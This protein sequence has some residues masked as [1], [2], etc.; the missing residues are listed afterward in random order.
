MLELLIAASFGGFD[1]QECRVAF[2]RREEVRLVLILRPE[3]PLGRASTTQ[4]VN[5]LLLQSDANEFSLAM[6]RLE[7]YPWLSN[8]LSRQ[9]SS[10]R[11]WN[12]AA[13]KPQSGSDN[14]YVSNA[15]AGMPEFTALFDRWRVAGVSVEKVL[16]RPAREI[17]LAAGAPVPPDARLPWDAIVWVYLKAP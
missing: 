2:E 11:R 13:G 14:A 12:L 15:L 5:R 1:A 6:G 10:S 17:Q 9:A 3:C 7:R 4:A 8:L 16:L